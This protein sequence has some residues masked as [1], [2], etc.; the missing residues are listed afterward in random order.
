MA[1]DELE[2][3]DWLKR[4]CPPHRAGELGIGDDMGIVRCGSD[5]LLVSSDML[6]DGVHFDSSRHAYPLIGR[7]ALACSLSDCAAMAVRPV[8]A[9]VS[10]ALPRSLSSA[11][12]KALYEGLIA[13]AEQF[14]LFVAGGDTTRW[15]HPLAIDV[16]ILAAPYS[17]AEPVTRSRARA[18]DRLFVTGPLGG[19]ILG[20][21]LSFTPRIHEARQVAEQLGDK[22]HA[23]IDI[24]DGLSLDLWRVCQASGVGAELEETLLAEVVSEDARRLSG[25]DGR[26]AL[27]HALSDGEDFELLLAV[28]EAAVTEEE[29][30]FPIGRVVE[31]GFAIRSPSGSLSPLRPT[32]YVH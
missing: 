17:N 13:L 29:P 10:V 30:L 12:T 31:Q 3:V 2:F 28:D 21:H 5:R 24:S 14:D 6:L 11:N 20:H 1:S 15:E 22:V 19:S 16:A 18:G 4:R 32:G 7:K 23:M 9:T 25:S 26:P 8:A 27:D